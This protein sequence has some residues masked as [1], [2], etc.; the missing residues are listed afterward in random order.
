[1]A[2][3]RAR[4]S[5]SERCVSAAALKRSGP[6]SFGGGNVLLSFL[7]R[8]RMLCIDA[9]L[10]VDAAAP[11]IRHRLLL[12][13]CGSLCRLLKLAQARLHVL[14]FD[15]FDRHAKNALGSP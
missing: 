1:M 10:V 4:S 9:L 5:S 12:L 3:R 2:S 15:P 11:A 8:L 13:L 14:D 7:S 6:V